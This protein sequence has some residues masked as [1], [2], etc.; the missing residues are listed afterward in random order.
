MEPKVAPSAKPNSGV[1]AVTSPADASASVLQP[2]CLWLGGDTGRNEDVAPSPEDESSISED[3]TGHSAEATALT[4]TL[5]RATN[6]LA[7][8]EPAPT[9]VLVTTVVA[10]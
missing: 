5:H 7:A 2:D 3:A 6:A 1:T 9:I 10:G 8:A 4:A